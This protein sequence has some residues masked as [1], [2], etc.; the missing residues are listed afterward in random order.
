MPFFQSSLLYLSS[1]LEKRHTDLVQSVL[2]LLFF[3]IY[4]ISCLALLLAFRIFSP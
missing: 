2:F 4:Y 1:E 3:I